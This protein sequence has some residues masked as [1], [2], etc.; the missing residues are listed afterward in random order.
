MTPSRV[1]AAVFFSPFF[2]PMCRKLG[3]T[4]RY[5]WHVWE[6]PLMEVHVSVVDLDLG[7]EI[8]RLLALV[9][10]VND[11]H[12]ICIRFCKRL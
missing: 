3:V 6:R 7:R 1:P 5:A 11:S 2:Y 10:P 9:Y 8:K 4:E 12:G